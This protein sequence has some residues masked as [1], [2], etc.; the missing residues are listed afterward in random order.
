MT[1]RRH[2]R[3][4]GLTQEALGEL[5]ALSTQAIGA[6]E[7]GD[8]RF[9]RQ[10]TVLRLA[11]ALGLTGQE[12]ADFAATAQSRKGQLPDEAGQP[13][14]PIS[15]LPSD[16]PD[17][18]GREEH[19]ERL[20]TSLRASEAGGV[21]VA[22]LVGGPGIGKSAL[23]MH[24]AHRIAG[25][26]PDGQ[27]YL[28]LAGTSGQPR[29]P[30]VML[31]ELLYA[32]GVVGG[33]LPDGLPARAALFRSL[34]A[35]RRMLLVC[36]DA[37][38]SDQ[39]RPLLPT[40]GCAVLVTSRQLLTDLAG[41]R[42]VELDVLSEPEAHQ[43]FAG[44][45]GPERVAAEPEHAAAILAACAHLPL[46]IRI[47]AGKLAGRPAWPLRLMH[48]RLADES[49]RLNELRLGDL[50]VRASFEASTDNLPA[51]AVRAFRLLALLGPH[52]VPGW[53]LGPLLDRPEADDTLD[54]LVDAN[55]LSFTGIDAT[56]WPRYRLHDLLRA[57]AD[58]GLETIAL[59]ERRAAVRRLLACW[60]DLT[61]RATHKLEASLFR[62]P[63]PPAAEPPIAMSTVTTV[64]RE[65]RR[66]FEAE[67]ATLIAAIELAAR[68]DEDELAWQLT[69]AA[70]P[71]YDQISHYEDWRRTHELALKPVRE[72]KNLRGEAALLRGL[73]Q[74]LLYCDVYDQATANFQRAL[75][76]AR[77]CGDDREAF[78]ATGGLATIDRVLGHYDKAEKHIRSALDIA[79]AG[80]D[81][82]LEAQMRN[83]LGMVLL[84]QDRCDEAQENFLAA[85][86][87]CRRIGDAHREAVVLREASQVFD[88][89]GETARAVDFLEQALNIFEKLED[90]RCV[91][92]TYLRAGRV[93]TRNANREPAVT[94]LE[95][96]VA[97][98]AQ[99]D[100][101]MEEAECWQLLGELDA[102]LGDVV[103]ARTKLERSLGLWRS[104]GGA[105][106]HIAKVSSALSS[107]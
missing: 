31:G 57:Y 28:D 97:Y 13:V 1:L 40:R 75:Q 66:W 5:A 51:D 11:D 94:A 61:V 92:F 52:T 23:A 93:H 104:I 37:A 74:I 29:D 24:V 6:L 78:L 48:E 88:R 26:F 96:A 36:D 39:V 21:P 34:L 41:A 50:G 18:T 80:D 10:D 90:D 95:N 72:K 27:F 68:W 86:R 14:A 73:G 47:A 8:R 82:G 101:R 58:E 85:L 55:L 99:H 70:V 35:D 46:A 2:R 84:A 38:N 44:I 4:K 87:L 59:D 7:R 81:R 42:H 77:Q 9:P 62:W 89:V 19:V 79:A 71:Y 100:N 32:L 15:Q 98:F 43:L 16:L 65:P 56:G 76:L 60:L 103:S 20:M 105:D 17:F 30:A 25:D 12:R 69:V 45:V 64:L 33:A 83:G 3:S 22:V 54:T 106:E 107:L 63:V 102:R 49:R 91:A 53:V 67:H